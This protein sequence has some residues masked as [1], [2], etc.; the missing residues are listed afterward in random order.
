VR[1][2]IGECGNYLSA[3]ELAALVDCKPNQR[4][5]MATWLANHK[6]KFEIGSTGLPKV[7]RAYH[8]RKMGVTEGKAQT[9]YDD[10]P[11]REAF[12]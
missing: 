1:T 9:K 4:S 6:W 2:I 12:A 10:E 11:N 7:S 8:D 5:K 3:D